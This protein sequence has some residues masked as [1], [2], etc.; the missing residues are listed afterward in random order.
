[1]KRLVFTSSR[2]VYGDPDTVPV[3]ESAPLQP[4]NAY[5]ASKAAGEMYCRTMGQDGMETVT[6]RLANVYGPGDHGRVIPIFVRNALLG[7]PLTLYGGDQV[8]DFVW[9]GTVVDALLRVGF[10]EFIGEPVNIASGKGTAVAALAR[11]IL[12]V[13]GSNAELQFGRT[14]T[15]E[16]ARFVADI[17]KASQFFA[18]TAAEDPLC[19]LPEVVGWMKTQVNTK[20]GVC[21]V[22]QGAGTRP[23]IVR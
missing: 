17:S 3:A 5:G 13:T 6:L 8:V 7:S 1:V 22:G 14:R 23:V 11:R 20:P 2:E 18:I 19:H 12:G 21:L 4:K 15:A 10:G 16:V 9:V